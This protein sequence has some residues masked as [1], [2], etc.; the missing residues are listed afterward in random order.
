[1]RVQCNSVGFTWC[2][3]EIVLCLVLTRRAHYVKDFIIYG[4]ECIMSLSLAS[5]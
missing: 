2:I 1:M 3:T 5:S 4:P